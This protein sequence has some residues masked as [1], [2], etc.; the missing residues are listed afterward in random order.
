MVWS[1]L[2]PCIYHTNGWQANEKWRWGPLSLILWGCVLSLQPFK[3]SFSSQNESNL[4]L[5][6]FFFMKLASS[7]LL[8]ISLSTGASQ[9]LHHF[10][11]TFHTSLCS[12]SVNSG[13]LSTCHFFLSPIFRLISLFFTLCSHNHRLELTKIELCLLIVKLIWLIFLC[14]T[15]KVNF[16]RISQAILFYIKKINEGWGYQAAKLQ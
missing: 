15:Q 13:S 6:L 11:S 1:P 2:F 14:E 9:F 4:S 7:A 16:W 3:S 10:S 5:Q 12:L 8:F